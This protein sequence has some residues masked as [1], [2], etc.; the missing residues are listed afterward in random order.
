MRGTIRAD[1]PQV[2]AVANVGKHLRRV[3]P[4]THSE[5][6]DDGSRPQAGDRTA[7]AH[8]GIALLVVEVRFHLRTELAAK[9]RRKEREQTSEPRGALHRSALRVSRRVARAASTSD[10]SR[11]ASAR[12]TVLP[13][14][15]SL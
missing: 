1:E 14:G 9:I 6:A 10:S 11:S 15:V 2:D 13:N 8:R 4:R 3:F 5:E 12:A 7:T